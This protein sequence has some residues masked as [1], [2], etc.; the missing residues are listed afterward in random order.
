[1]KFSSYNLILFF[2]YFKVCFPGS[3][4][5]TDGTTVGGLPRGLLMDCK[6]NGPSG[7]VLREPSQDSRVAERVHSML[8]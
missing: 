4:L 8:L 1:M 7:P 2:S 5:Q 6:S 3:S